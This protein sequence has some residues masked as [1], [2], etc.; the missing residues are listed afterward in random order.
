MTIVNLGGEVDSVKASELETRV[1]GLLD[2]GVKSLLID[3][4]HLTYI[5]SAGLRVFLLAAKQLAQDGTL[6][7]CGL[8]SERAPR[9]RDHRF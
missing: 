5:N 2:G 6:A 4:T 8:A 1:M 7:F 9:L 3:C